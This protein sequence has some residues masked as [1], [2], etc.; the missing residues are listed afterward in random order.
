MEE[1][2]DQAPKLK[3][4]GPPGLASCR[5]VDEFEKLNRIDEGAYGVVYR[6]RDKVTGDIVALKKVKMEKEK[7]GFPVTSLRELHILL[8]LRHPNV[9]LVREIV[10][11]NK[12]D[13]IFMVMEFMEHDLRKLMEDMRHSYRFSQSEVKCLLMQLLR[14]CS[15]MHYNWVIHRD[16]K[17][18]NL[19]LNNQGQLKICDF[20]L[21][22]H[23]GDPLKAMTPLVVTLWY[24]APELLLGA[25]TYNANIDMWSV[26][27][28]FGEL[29]CKKPLFR[30]TTEPEQLKAIFDVMGTPA[31]ADW[32]G[33]G[34]L[35]GYKKL[36]LTKTSN[37]LRKL[38]PAQALLSGSQIALSDQGFD[39][40]SRM[41]NANPDK[42]ITADEALLHPYFA[43]HPLAKEEAMMPTFPSAHEDPSQ[44]RRARD[45]PEMRLEAQLRRELLDDEARFSR[46]RSIVGGGVPGVIISKK[47]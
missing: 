40:L 9:V 34:N 11:G 6:A 7:E 2:I 12:T 24:R 1:I 33:V 4:R 16:L 36:N 15:Y 19:L 28:I 5:H 13:L 45:D 17:T 14:G 20:G 26:G 37:Q 43:E 47:R 39:L 31:E 21:S 41:L 10:V 42:R 8:K 32:P 18:S 25:K 46:N 44:R 35:P 23:Y 27:C 38:F 29:L 3:Y 22:R 30:G